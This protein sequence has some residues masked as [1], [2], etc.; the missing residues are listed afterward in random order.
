MHEI[1]YWNSTIA[2]NYNIWSKFQIHTKD[3]IFRRDHWDRIIRLY[4]DEFSKNLKDFVGNDAKLPTYDE[5]LIDVRASIPISIFFCA[6]FRDLDQ[7]ESFSSMDSDMDPVFGNEGLQ[8]ESIQNLRGSFHK[9]QNSYSV[10][11]LHDSSQTIREGNYMILLFTLVH[12]TISIFLF[13]VF[14]LSS[15]QFSGKKI[16]RKVH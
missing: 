5:F 7:S 3:F 8:K 16:S 1:F 12:H 14:F 4:F 6:N 2:I 9:L 15:T 13:I 10:Y 11:F